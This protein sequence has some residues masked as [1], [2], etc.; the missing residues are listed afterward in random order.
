[1]MKRYFVFLAAALA[2]A[3]T[4]VFVPP[5]VSDA[6]VARNPTIS[7]SGTLDVASLLDGAGATHTIVA[8]QAALG[9]GCVASMGV[10]LAGMTV[11]CS[12]NAAGVVAVR[13]QNESAATVD[14]AS[15]TLRV[16][17]FKLD[18]QPK[19]GAIT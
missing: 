16:V 15:T 7:Y 8:S 4:F 13:F 3:A 17:V 14:L 11:T 9:D 12:V 10:S 5:I 6:A 19:A 1:M 2:L 18:P